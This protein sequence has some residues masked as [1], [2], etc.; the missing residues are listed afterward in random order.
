MADDEKVSKPDNETINVEIDT[1]IKVSAPEDTPKAAI[2][3]AIAKAFE[4]IARKIR[5]GDHSS[6]EGEHF[7][8]Q[9]VQGQV[10]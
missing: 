1:N 10:N 2:Q 6:T 7:T 5:S 4:D 9:K 3:E 8:M